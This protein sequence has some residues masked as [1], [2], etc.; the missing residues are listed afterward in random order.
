MIKITQKGLEEVRKFIAILPHGI[1]VAAMREATEYIIGDERHGLKHEPERVE[2]GEDNPYK[3]T[4]AKQR[5][6]FFATDG[7]GRGIPSE[8]THGLSNGWTMQEA[9]S[10]W[11]TVKIENEAPEAVWVMGDGQQ[12]G[13]KADGW[14]YW[15]D[16]VASNL[17]GAI[18][19]AQQAVDAWLKTKGY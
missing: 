6:A 14:R 13:H 12:I 4:S 15:A 1:K 11:N 5:S 2:H 7:F 18:R 10:D 16:V 3:W 17:A 9:N 8:R 19:S